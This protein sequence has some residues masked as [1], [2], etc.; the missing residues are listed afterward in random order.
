MPAHFLLTATARNFTLEDL[1]G[2][3]EARARDYFARC[4]W[5][6]EGTQVCPECGTIDKHYWIRTR[7]QWRCKEI[8]CGR[9]FSVTSGTKFADHKLPLRKILKAA[10]IFAANVKGISASALARQ[11][12]VAYQT[13]FVLLHK[14][15]E[16]IAEECSPA[17][18]DGIVHMDG[19]HVSGRLRKPRVKEPTN[20]AQA[21]DR[22]DVAANPTHRNRRIV[23]VMRTV[24]PEKGKGAV[25]T[26]VE[27]TR[28]ET[29]EIAAALAKKY[30]KR[31]ATVHTDEHPAYSGFM[32]R[33]DHE[34]VNHS[35][36]F[37]SDAGV[38]NNQAES[39]FA[40]MRR[41]VIGQVHRVTPRYMVSYAREVAWREDNRRM[42]PSVLV[43]D[44][45]K[46]SLRRAARDWCG[47]WQ[48]KRRR[49]EDIFEP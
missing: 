31:D 14:L 42:P 37:S 47:Y 4:R 8:A 26:V 33:Y 1:E 21:R 13:A 2:M 30:I 36:H 25:R 28:G 9:F 49:T 6:D 18:L 20:K 40:R 3:T 17:Q 34:T 46:A 10:L 32:A 23:M 7:K 43:K 11:I 27:V 15:R 22:V 19:A 35:T 44:L 12:N 24:S 41:M 38:S 45:V 16:G 5:G 29:A 48:R 39:Y